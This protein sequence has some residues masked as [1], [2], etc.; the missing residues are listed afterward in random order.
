MH[1]AKHFLVMLGVTGQFDRRDS[2][3]LGFRLNFAPGSWHTTRWDFLKRCGI[4]REAQAMG[5]ILRTMELI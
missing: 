1:V 3:A 5:K 2:H 4:M